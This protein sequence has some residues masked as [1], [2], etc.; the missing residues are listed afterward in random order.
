MD[1]QSWSVKNEDVLTDLVALMGFTAQDEALLAALEPEA[2]QVAPGLI[3]AFYARLSLHDMTLEHVDGQTMKLKGTLEQ[4]FLRLFQGNYGRDYVQSRLRIGQVH[5]RIGLPVRYPLAMLD[6]ILQG[7]ESVA[8]RSPQPEMVVTAFNKL[9][10]MDIAIFNQAYEDTQLRH[11]AEL[12]GN[13]RLARRLLM[14]GT[15]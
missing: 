2:R 12:M 15:S 6:V 7:G 14:Q 1:R 13:E 10:A 4:W 9:M 8:R 5:V 3:E 11:L